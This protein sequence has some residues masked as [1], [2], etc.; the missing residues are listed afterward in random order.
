MKIAA[1]FS[2]LFLV[3]GLSCQ[4]A[5]N[6]A[7]TTNN[8]DHQAVGASAHDLLSAA[9]YDTVDIEME[10]MPGF[11]PDPGAVNNL[12]SF[13]NMLVNKPGG[14]QVTQT[15]V[16][17]SG[18]SVLSQSDVENIENQYRTLSTKG[19]HLAIY[20]LF[21]NGNYTN[22]AVLGFAYRNTSICIFGKTIRDNSG[23]IGQIDATTLESAVLEHEMGHIMG[24]VNL[25]SPMQTPHEDG[26]HANHC[27]NQHCLMYYATETTDALAFL[28]GGNVPALDA[29]CRADLK[30][31]GGK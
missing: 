28:T 10:Y 26:A 9:T 20:I 12:S 16:P 15:Q 21:T 17:A 6:P 14:I 4:K 29:N 27:N 22:N 11:Q 1:F 3:A 7:P 18:S 8:Y 19:G 23:G 2:L 13:L 30:A 25:G 5:S 31:N 24:L